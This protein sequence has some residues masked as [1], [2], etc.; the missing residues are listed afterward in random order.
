MRIWRNFS[1]IMPD[2]YVTRRLVLWIQI[3]IHIGVSRTTIHSMKF[4]PSIPKPGE[5]CV[6]RVLT[7]RFIHPSTNLTLG[8]LRVLP[9]FFNMALFLED[10]KSSN[11]NKTHTQRALKYVSFGLSVAPTVFV[12]GC[13]SIESEIDL[14]HSLCDCRNLQHPLC[15]LSHGMSYVFLLVVSRLFS[16][17]WI[18]EV[19][20]VHLAVQLFI[21]IG[22]LSTGRQISTLH[23]T[24]AQKKR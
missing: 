15:Q 18:A 19:A 9:F 11:N 1:S 10:G 2:F 14:Y 5:C 4:H 23:T 6:R 20:D 12:A 7:V 22:N 21:V 13:S 3:W 24:D 8:F 17:V 16:S